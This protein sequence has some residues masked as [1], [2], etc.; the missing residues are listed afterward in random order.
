[1]ALKRE[2]AREISNKKLMGDVYCSNEQL[3]VVS[4]SYKGDIGVSRD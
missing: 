2:L 4:E 3:R 1:M